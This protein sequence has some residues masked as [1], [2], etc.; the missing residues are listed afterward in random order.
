[1]GTSEA[2]AWLRSGRRGAARSM[3]WCGQPLQ[4]TDNS[5]KNR[6]KSIMTTN[7]AD[8]RTRASSP[9]RVWP[10]AAALLLVGIVLAGCGDSDGAESSGDARAALDAWVDG[11][12]AHSVD[13]VMAAFAED[14]RLIDHPLY[15]GESA[16]KDQI[17]RGVAET[18]GQA[19]RDPDAYSVSDV[20]TDG[21]TVSWSYVWIQSSG[22]DFCAE[23]NEIDVNDEGLIIELR[24]GADPGECDQ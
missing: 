6:G 15:P 8:Q 21:D 13:D 16:G 24:W 10:A 17:R 3:P 9:R 2:L 22:T 14:S 11:I 18:V 4:R 19:R 20:V 1:M 23:G 5:T 7:K 12:N